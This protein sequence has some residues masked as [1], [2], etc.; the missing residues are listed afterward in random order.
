MDD[1][2]VFA[3]IDANF[4]LKFL[5]PRNGREGI[6]DTVDISANGV[7]IITDEYLSAKTPL[8]MW[9]QI[10]DQHE[11]LYL[12]GEVV[13]SEGLSDT[14]RQRAGVHLEN[15]RLMSLARVLWFKRRSGGTIG[16]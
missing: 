9:L 1:Q 10:P 15:A 6:A 14:P 8:E 12:R 11:P 16:D 4:P 2:R 7:G 5:D 3:R 13:W